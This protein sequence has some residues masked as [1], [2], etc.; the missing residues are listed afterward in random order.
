MP[1]SMPDFTGRVTSLSVPPLVWLG[2]GVLGFLLTAA[3]LSYSPSGRI[4]ILWIWGI[5][6]FLPALG[7][8]V[9]LWAVVKGAQTPWLFQ[10]RQKG[11]PWFPEPVVRW[12]MFFWLQWFW[13]VVALGMVV[14]FGVHLVFTDLAFAWSTTVLLDSDGLATGLQVIALPW[15]GFWPA[16][17]PDAELLTNTRFERIDP[18]A[19]TVQATDWWPFLLASL[20]FYN[21]LPRLLLAGLCYV[22]W[23]LLQRTG[24]SITHRHED[25]GGLSTLDELQQAPVSA[26]Q[27]DPVVA[28]EQSRPEAALVLGLQGWDDDKQA[29]DDFL[30][31]QPKRLCWLVK[32]EH[33]PVAELADLMAL[34][35]QAG[36][37]T[38]SIRTYPEPHYL[39]ER[40]WKSW[41]AFARRQHA[42]WLKE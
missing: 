24:V 4:N 11:A 25:K 2:A 39:S 34:A 40:Q 15:S 7:S 8:L 3:S 5:W 19:S 16:A 9:S 35:R 42:V 20:L 1:H 14:G 38:Q 41:Q 28:W 10:W 23:R 31:R 21:L 27:G 30:Q 33:S 6:A 37:R 26:W 32:G 12:R 22:R 29:L 36:V 17:V 18:A 13:C